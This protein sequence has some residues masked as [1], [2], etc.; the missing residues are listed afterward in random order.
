MF[1][2]R[3]FLVLGL[4]SKSLSH[5]E[6]I[7]MYGVSKCSSWIYMRLTDLL[8]SSGNTSGFYCP[9]FF[10]SPEAEKGEGGK[11]KQRNISFF[12]FLSFFFFSF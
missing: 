1:F 4:I 8:F 12:S 11:T 9:P 7:F 5:F 2:I 6:C 3:N 10:L